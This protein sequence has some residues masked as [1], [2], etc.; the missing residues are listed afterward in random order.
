ME[1]KEFTV[2]KNEDALRML[3]EIKA[4]NTGMAERLKAPTWYHPALGLLTGG[5]AA[6]QAAPV[7]WMY[8]YYVVFGLGLVVLVRSYMRKTGMWVSGYRAGRTRIVAVSLAVITGALMVNSAWLFR[9]KHLTWVPLVTAVVL[10]VIVTIAGFVW[11]AAF[12]K[13]MR[14]GGS[15]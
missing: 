6:V 9:S 5:L 2:T 15:L 13:D 3:A 14:E 10:A 4:A 1:S 8:V 7:I 11:E 12:R